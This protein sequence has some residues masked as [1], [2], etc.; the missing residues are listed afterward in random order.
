[1]GC[2]CAKPPTPEEFLTPQPAAPSPFMADVP[3]QLLMNL[4]PMNGGPTALNVQR[5]GDGALLLTFAM[6]KRNAFGV[7]AQA[8]DAQGNVVA[9]FRTAESSRP[10]GINSSSYRLFCNRPA[11]ANQ[12]PTQIDT[13]TQGYLWATATRAPFTNNIQI[14][15]AAGCAP[16]P[17]CLCFHRSGL[18]PRRGSNLILTYKL[19][20]GFDT[21]G[22]Q[23][24]LVEVPGGGGCLHASKAATS[25]PSWDIRLAEGVDGV[26]AMLV[27]QLS[28]LARDEVRE[29]HGSHH[30]GNYGDMGGGMGP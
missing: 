30:D 14:Y 24:R 10:H 18:E 28:E 1:M 17:P 19:C 13:V 23:T 9:W 8:A 11:M 22:M 25:P 4:W 27:W 29:E 5:G 6:P 21:S 3:R 7:G 26:F 15:D 12:Q 16:A 20:M 2:C